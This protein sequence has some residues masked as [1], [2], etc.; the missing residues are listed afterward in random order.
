MTNPHI[1]S[2]MD[3]V[4]MGSSYKPFV[5]SLA[6]VSVNAI[7]EKLCFKDDKNSEKIKNPRESNQIKTSYSTKGKPD[8]SSHISSV[9]EGNHH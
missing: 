6:H 5:S 3:R 1:S 2:Q 4:I 9:M 7:I 8:T